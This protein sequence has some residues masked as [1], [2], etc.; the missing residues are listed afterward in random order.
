MIFVFA[1]AFAAY[2]IGQTL[3]ISG[4]VTSQENGLP[5]PGVSVTVKGTTLGVLTA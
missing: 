3:Q 4:I 5:V 1:F 2:S